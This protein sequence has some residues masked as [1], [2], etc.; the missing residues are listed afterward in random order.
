MLDP[1]FGLRYSGLSFGKDWKVVVEAAVKAPIGGRRDLLSTGRTD[2]GLQMTLQ[3]FADHHAWYISGSAVYYAGSPNF[4][5]N[6]SE[7]IPT[8]VAGYERHLGDNTHLILQG[9]LSPSVYSHQDTDLD[10]LLATKFQASIGLYHRIGSSLISFA[11]T[12]N[13]QNLNNTP[14]IG[15]QFGFAYSPALRARK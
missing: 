11:I 7:I 12:E 8:L 10:E 4:A 6:D 1:T 5:P 15:F 14:D 3:K 13:L 9:Y 2:Y